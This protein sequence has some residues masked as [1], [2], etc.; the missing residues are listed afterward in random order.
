MLSQ[1]TLEENINL[2]YECSLNPSHW[3]SC[4]E[5][6]AS[7]IN[8]K[9]AMIGVDDLITNTHLTRLQYGYDKELVQRM[10]TEL[11]NKDVW[12]KALIESKSQGFVTDAV[13]KPKDGST[14]TGEFINIMNGYDVHHTAGAY[15]NFIDN[16]GIR[17]AFQRSL[18]QGTYFKR[19]TNY[20]DNLL[21]HIKHSLKLSRLLTQNDVFTNI[22]TAELE[23]HS[24]PLFLTTAKGKVL[25]S[26]SKALSLIS[27]SHHFEIKSEYFSVKGIKPN[28]LQSSIASACRSDQVINLSNQCDFL[29]ED[30]LSRLYHINITRFQLNESNQLTILPAEKRALALI[31]VKAVETNN[32]KVFRLSQLYGLSSQ[33]TAVAKYLADGHSPKEISKIRHRSI[34]TVRTQV[35]QITAKMNAKSIN[36]LVYKLN[37]LLK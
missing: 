17:I 10:T 37:Q 6:I 15:A 23:R 32:T 27:E 12:T 1:Y 4:L 21:P 33:E 11:K 25:F 13:L 31:R 29:I 9:S 18:N 24:E 26:N 22:S 19:E 5:S 7:C 34:E 36:D 35:K 30:K 16:M 28:A 20:L 3:A 8:A 14:W 2:I